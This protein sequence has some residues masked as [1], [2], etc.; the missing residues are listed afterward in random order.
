VKKS[1]G[2]IVNLTQPEVWAELHRLRNKHTPRN[3]PRDNRHTPC[4]N[5][6]PRAKH[7][8]KPTP[9]PW[10]GYTQTSADYRQQLID[11]GFLKPASSVAQKATSA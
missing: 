2:T 11:K 5:E 6:Q 10:S 8:R 1:I 3:T 7:P 9:A 4:D